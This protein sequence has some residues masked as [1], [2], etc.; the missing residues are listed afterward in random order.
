MKK[1]C[2]IKIIAVLTIFIAA[3]M[4]IIQNHFDDWVMNPVKEFF[5][6]AFVSGVDD[7]LNFIEESPEKDSLRVLLKDYLQKKFV[8]TKELSNKDIDWL[9]DSVKVVVRD[10]FITQKDLDKLKNLIE[11]KGYERSEED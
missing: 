4:Y 5:S 1:G 7:E 2:F 10:S 11:I 8:N 6:E 3:V 9:I